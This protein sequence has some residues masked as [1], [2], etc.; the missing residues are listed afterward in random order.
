M[1]EKNMD[2]YENPKRSM[3][4]I[5]DE[6][7]R[8]LGKLASSYIKWMLA[9]N[10]GALLWFADMTLDKFTSNSQLVF[11]WWVILII[12]FLTVS[13]IIL[14]KINISFFK[15]NLEFEKLIVKY[16]TD[17]N[18][19]EHL[20]A[21]N[22]ILPSEKTGYAAEIFFLIGVISMASYFITYLILFK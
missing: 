20:N 9:I 18:I 16:Y 4:R 15:I 10:T 2:K 1:K 14:Y 7:N 6:T 17:Q 11:K 8:S 13:E 19:D 5:F 22:Q 12:F 21:I 3:D